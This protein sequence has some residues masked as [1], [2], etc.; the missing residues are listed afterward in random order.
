MKTV[1]LFVIFRLCSG[2]LKV[3]FFGQTG[4]EKRACIDR[5]ARRCLSSAGLPEDPDH[6]KS[7]EYLRIFHVEDEIEVAGDYIAYLDRFN[8]VHQRTSWNTAWDLI[9]DECNADKPKH[10]F[11]S[12]HATCFRKNRFFSVVDIDRIRKFQ[13]DSIVTLIDDAHECWARIQT[14]E[15]RRPR[16]TD[17]RLRD[18][19]LW[20]TVEIMAGDFLRDGTTDHYVVAT[21]HP[22]EMVRRLIF[23]QE[24]KR[25][26]AS[27]PISSTREK[28]ESKRQIDDFRISLHK[29]FATFDPITIDERILATALK[30]RRKGTKS[31]KLDNKS[32]WEPALTEELSPLQPPTG[33]LYPF[34]IPVEQV[35]EVTEDIDRQIEARDYRLIGQAQAVVAYRPNFMQ[36]YARGVNAELLYASQTCGIPVH[37]VWNDSEDG[38][39]ADSPFGNIGTKHKSV[40]NA[41]GA[42]S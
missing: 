29:Q 24:T 25:V 26:Y 39:F 12:L 6:S 21:K 3:L 1:T 16:G 15:K 30:S 33:N 9:S 8:T 13:P 42:I 19:F 28:P 40:Q 11:V 31:V 36:H 18:I 4:V 7:M 5:L 37:V 27:F 38:Q 14:R 20:R 35:E 34:S 22:A 10:V 2:T 23:E 32:R 17:L 41:I